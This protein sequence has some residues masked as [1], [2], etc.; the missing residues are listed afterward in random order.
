MRYLAGALAF[1]GVLATLVLLAV[2][3][4]VKAD[5]LVCLGIVLGAAGVIVV[6]ILSGGAKLSDIL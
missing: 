6:G 1:L 4:N 3:A 5:D 2:F